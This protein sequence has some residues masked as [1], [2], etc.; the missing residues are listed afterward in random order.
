MLLVITPASAVYSDSNNSSENAGF[1]KHF[2]PVGEYLRSAII[3]EAPQLMIDSE[4]QSKQL[5]LGIRI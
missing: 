2:E 4:Q 5:E 3:N 1:G